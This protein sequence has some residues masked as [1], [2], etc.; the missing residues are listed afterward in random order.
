MAVLIPLAF[1]AAGVGFILF[2]AWR[3][4]EAKGALFALLLYFVLFGG[5]LGCLGLGA[6][7]YARTG[8]FVS[9]TLGGILEACEK[10]GLNVGWLKVAPWPALQDLNRWY[11]ELNLGWTLLVVPGVLIGVWMLLPRAAP[12]RK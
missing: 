5:T 10:A 1:L 2:S 7:G 6:W 12:K 8:K 11:L 9:I 3:D 4:P